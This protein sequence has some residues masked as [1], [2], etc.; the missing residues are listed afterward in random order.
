[1]GLSIGSEKAWRKA[2]L[3][4]V[5]ERNEADLVKIL[6]QH[7]RRPEWSMP[8]FVRGQGDLLLAWMVGEG[9]VWGVG[10]LL[11][12]GHRVDPSVVRRFFD[13]LSGCWDLPNQARYRAETLWPCLLPGVLVDPAS[14]QE[15]VLWILRMPVSQKMAPH[16]GWEAL[17]M[18]QLVQGLEGQP[19]PLKEW[20]A[21]L[22]PLQLAWLFDKPDFAVRLIEQASDCRY[23]VDG[24]SLGPWTLSA[25]LMLGE[26]CQ[27][28]GC[29][30]PQ[31]FDRMVQIWGVSMKLVEGGPLENWMAAGQ[32][33]FQEEMLE[34]WRPVR[35]L[36]EA[37]RLEDVLPPVGL[38]VRL[39]M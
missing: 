33:G 24:T 29:S 28:E 10:F 9:S 3:Q 19:L 21:S 12:R 17:G 35:T 18:G 2:F 39:R 8:G 30:S 1:M 20:K 34:R 5:R 38:G 27:K 32:S 11:E 22:T 15:A 26:E 14:R 7:A 36:L 37:F 4:A 23:W 16:V 6:A 13:G 25:A 31:F